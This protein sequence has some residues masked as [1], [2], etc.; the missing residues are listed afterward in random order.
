[1]TWAPAA[2]TC[3]ESWPDIEGLAPRQRLTDETMPS[4]TFFDAAVLP[5]L[6]TTTL[7]RLQQFYP[8]G[9]FDARRF[10]PNLVVEPIQAIDGFLEDDWTGQILTIG[11][12]VRIRVRG[13]CQR[14]VMTK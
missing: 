10:R 2:P 14:C 11:D 6:T 13:P 4:R 5:L 8:G 12:G 7:D 9:R 1:M 3:Q